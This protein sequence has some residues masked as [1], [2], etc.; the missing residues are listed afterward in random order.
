MKLAAFDMANKQTFDLP[1]AL[2]SHLRFS[3]VCLREVLRGQKKS[4]SA[5]KRPLEIY[6]SYA[7]VEQTTI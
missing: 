2:A 3:S 6:L 4:H 7:I 5:S 1:L